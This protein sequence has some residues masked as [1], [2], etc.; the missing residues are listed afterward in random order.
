MEKA[1]WGVVST[2]K[3]GV[4]KVIPGIQNSHLGRVVAIASRDLERARTAASQ[5]GIDKAYGSYEDLLADPDIEFIY[6]PLPNDQHVDVT[7]AAARAG[8]H[9]LC[10]KPIGLSAADAAR[11]SEIPQDIRVMEAFMVRYHPQWLRCRE[12]LHSGRIGTPRAIQVAFSYFNDD[13]QNIRNKPETGGGALM[14]I[15]CY[16]IVTGRFFFDADPA[17]VVGLIDRDPAFETDRLTSGLLDFG[18]GRQLTFTVSTQT[19]PYQRVQILGT[20]GR[21]E[22]EIPFNA[23]Q[24]AASRLF[25]YDGAALDGSDAVQET[26]P[27]ADQYAEQADAL[28]K[29]VRDGEAAPTGVEDAITNMQIIDALF[30][31]ADRGTWEKP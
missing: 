7:L 25:I 3:I 4:E 16:A 14:D 13:P 28:V 19:V 5:L 20:R 27:A 30:R 15:G 9:V 22:I 8:K 24:G 2:A 11:L 23:P 31:S 10:E 12:I 18:D 6:N 21:L 17:R 26:L 1:R 29:A